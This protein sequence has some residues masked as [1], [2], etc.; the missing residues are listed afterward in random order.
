RDVGATSIEE[1][2]AAVAAMRA[3]GPGTA[4]AAPATGRAN[5]PSSLPIFG[6]GTS[7]ATSSTTLN[8]QIKLEVEAAAAKAEAA[9][10]ELRQLQNQLAV[11]P[12]AVLMPGFTSESNHY[13]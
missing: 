7:V 6:M 5:L 4:L 11:A 10:A 12:R 9:V 2:R 13:H 1:V 3:A 8:P